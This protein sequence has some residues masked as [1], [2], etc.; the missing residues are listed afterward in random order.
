[1]ND[2]LCNEGERGQKNA[3]P[4]W[5]I[6]QPDSSPASARL[7]GWSFMISIWQKSSGWENV[8][9]LSKAS[10]QDI[11][12]SEV[13]MGLCF[14]PGSCSN[15][16]KASLTQGT[17]VRNR[18]RYPLGRLEHTTGRVFNGNL[19]REHHPTLQTAQN[20]VQQWRNKAPFALTLVR[21]QGASMVCS[22]IPCQSPAVTKI[23]HAFKMSPCCSYTRWSHITRGRCCTSQDR[24]CLDHVLVIPKQGRCKLAT[25][26]PLHTWLLRPDE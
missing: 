21:L 22:C 2:C 16:T 7:A 20:R 3:L 5:Q 17:T 12:F 1:M 9:K 8:M 11:R 14:L 19:P 4:L 23:L 10:H 24:A 26:V 15:S 6:N 25:A 18:N 13:W